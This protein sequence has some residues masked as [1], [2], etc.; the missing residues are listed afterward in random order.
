MTPPLFLSV[1]AAYVVAMIG[2]SLWI[3]RRQ[4]SGEDF[5]LGDRSIELRQRQG[6]SIR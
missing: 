1:F 4:R 3:A 2:L 6:R 5:L